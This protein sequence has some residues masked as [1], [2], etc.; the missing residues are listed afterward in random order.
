MQSLSRGNQGLVG[1]TVRNNGLSR[2]VERGSARGCRHGLGRVAGCRV[3]DEGE[4]AWKLSCLAGTVQ[5]RASCHE[6]A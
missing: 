1:T 2:G 3:E 5:Q 6:R 4:R